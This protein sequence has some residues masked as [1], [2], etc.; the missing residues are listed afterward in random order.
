VEDVRQG[1]YLELDLNET[2]AEQARAAVES[3][4]ARLLANTVI[5]DFQIELEDG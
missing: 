5:E 2:D 4:C 1:K 3:M